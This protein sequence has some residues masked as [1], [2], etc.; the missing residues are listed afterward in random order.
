[1]PRCYGCNSP[2]HYSEQCPN[3]G[4]KKAV[5]CYRC[6]QPGH[7]SDHCPSASIG[8]APV[9]VPKKAVNCYRCG[10]A[11]H[12]S[13]HCPSAEISAAPVAPKII[14][15]FK[16]GQPGHY[17][18]HCPTAGV[19]SSVAAPM[20]TGTCFICGSKDH[21]KK[22]CP[23]APVA[24]DDSKSDDKSARP[25]IACVICMTNKV[26]CQFLPCRHINSCLD[27]AR[28]VLV[29]PFC[30]AAIESREQVFIDHA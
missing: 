5:S 22:D 25:S 3:R 24:Q 11:G 9:S 4:R 17:S 14:T 8:A 1:M 7:Y 21:Y 26:N 27:C 19:A 23:R 10:Q 16:C 2:Y 13:D 28:S 6:G 15:C 29:C 20:R 18:D 30:R 12:Y